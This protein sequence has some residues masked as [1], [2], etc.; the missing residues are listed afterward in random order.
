MGKKTPLYD[1]HIELG[2]KMVDFAGFDL[3]V[4]Y[5]SVMA[6]HKATR[7]SV[8][9]FD[10]S[11]MGELLIMGENAENALNYIVSNDI[12][13]MYDGQVRYTLLPNENGGAIDDVLVYRQAANKFWLVVNGANVE[14]DA[15]WVENHLPKDIFFSNRSEEIAQIAVQGPCSQKVLHKL[16]SEESI[17]KKYY[18]F[19]SDVKINGIDC[20]ISRTGYT[21]EDGFELYC[22]AALSEQLYNQLMEAGK[23]FDITPCGLGAR[24]TLRLEGAMPLYGHE[25]GDNISIDEVGLNFAIKMKKE[26]FIGKNI[27]ENHVPEFARVGAKVVGRGIARENAKVFCG[28]QEIGVVTSGTHSPTLG[29]PICMLRIK[30]DYIDKDLTVEIRNKKVEIKVVDMP[31]YKRN[32]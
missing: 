7:N 15:Q 32:K 13:G 25:L 26:N 21:A 23:E 6:E 8:G 16:V 20:V 31:F 29:Y 18:S 14:K 5:S 24:D 30:K 12:S 4:Q 10:V 9:L 19:I 27:L 1:K 11:H 28:D 3:P 17:P 2:G 22:M